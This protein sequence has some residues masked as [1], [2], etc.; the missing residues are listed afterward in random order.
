MTDRGAAGGAHK[1]D[2]EAAR[3]GL[4][5]ARRRSRGLIKRGAPRRV[6][7][8]AIGVAIFVATV[9]FGVVLEQIVLAQSA[10][11]MARIRHQ[12]AVEETKHQELV[13]EAT[14][15]E[16]PM[17][18]EL[19][20]RKQLSMVEPDEIDYL[21]ADVAPPSAGL[22]ATRARPPSGRPAL[23]ASPEH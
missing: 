10:F 16:S 19:F 17:R 3:P 12:L 18:I 15:L 1:R 14:Q 8:V 11:K 5:V 21:V 22:F 20:A 9:V 2:S 4:A 13:L 23:Y 6:A 7:P